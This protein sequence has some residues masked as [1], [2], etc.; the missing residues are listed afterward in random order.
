MKPDLAGNVPHCTFHLANV[1]VGLRC[2]CRPR[3]R[4]GAWVSLARSKQELLDPGAA[5]EL[6]AQSCAFRKFIDSLFRI[7]LKNNC[8]NARGI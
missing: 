1:R 5:G 2:S 4:W 8:C 3:A 7:V 6:T